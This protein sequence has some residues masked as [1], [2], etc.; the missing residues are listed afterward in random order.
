MRS[1]GLSGC[2]V[3][4]MVSDPNS[5]QTKLDV[6]LLRLIEHSE[7][8]PDSLQDCGAETMAEQRD[9]KFHADINKARDVAEVELADQLKCLAMGKMRRLLSSSFLLG[10]QALLDGMHHL[11]QHCPSNSSHFHHA[12]YRQPLVVSVLRLPYVLRLQN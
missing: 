9:C 11:R 6:E 4:M 2:E 5:A 8:V 10:F 7:R 12:R 1:D 3:A